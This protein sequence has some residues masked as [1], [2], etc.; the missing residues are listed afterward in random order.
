[1][2]GFTN[3]LQVLV[4]DERLRRLELRARATGASVGALVR[5]A[6]DVA[7]P[8]VETDRERAGTALLEAAPMPVEDW[9]AMKRDVESMLGG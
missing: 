5:D 6:I 3:R 1:M 7:Y 4:D 8:G 9:D 2:S